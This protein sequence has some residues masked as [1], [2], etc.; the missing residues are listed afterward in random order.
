MDIFLHKDYFQKSRV[1]LYSSLGFKRGIRHV[2]E[3]TYVKWKNYFDFEEHKLCLLY[4]DDKS[5]L[6]KEYEEKILIKHPQF[7]DC[8]NVENNRVV[9][10]YD[11][12]PYADDWKWFMHSK[13]SYFSE[14]HK[15]KILNFYGKDTPNYPYVESFLYPSKYYRLFADLLC[16]E[17]YHLETVKELCT[18]INK[19]RETLEAVVTFNAIN[20][21]F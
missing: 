20:S 16:I 15:K 7:Y 4:K 19:E 10:I 11:F 1:F 21:K 5:S 17:Q 2:P 8:K 14:Q 3:E 12:S 6:F 18:K 13:F 9:F